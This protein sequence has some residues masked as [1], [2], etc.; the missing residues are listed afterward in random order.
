MLDLDEATAF[1]P[2]SRGRRFRALSL[3]TMLEQTG[4]DMLWA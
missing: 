2:K 3:T 1:D 4:T